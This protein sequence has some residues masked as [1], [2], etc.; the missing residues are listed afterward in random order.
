MDSIDELK[1]RLLLADL[2]VEVVAV[3]TLLSG[4]PSAGFTPL[5]SGRDLGTF[6]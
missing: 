3:L 2:H 4:M 1:Q 6:G 5:Y